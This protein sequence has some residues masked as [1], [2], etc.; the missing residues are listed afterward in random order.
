MTSSLAA[1]I[2]VAG[3]AFADHEQ[4]RTRKIVVFREGT[5]QQIRRR[6]VERHGFQVL[7]HLDL[8]NAVAIEL[9]AAKAEMAL[10]A[11][12][13]DSRVVAIDEDLMASAEHVVSITPVPPPALEISPWGVQQ[14]GVPHVFDLIASHTLSAPMVAMMDTGIDR[15]HLELVPQIAGGYNARAGEN[16]SDYQDH[17]GHGTHVAGIIAATWN[18]QGIIGTADA[19]LVAVKVFDNTGHGYLSDLVYGL[20]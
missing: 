13:S 14:I 4:P 16:S 17:N 15:S 2:L 12:R 18:G 11:L 6:V 1:I 10:A 20:Q 3:V 8:L 5:T 7:H 19:N 9:P